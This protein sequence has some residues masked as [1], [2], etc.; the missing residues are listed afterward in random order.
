MEF[1]ERLIRSAIHLRIFKRKPLSPTFSGTGAWI[2]HEGKE[3]LIT[4]QHVTLKRNSLALIDTGRDVN[5]KR[6]YIKIGGRFDFIKI[7]L[8]KCIPE[9]I[10]N[11]ILEYTKNPDFTNSIIDDPEIENSFI[12]FAYYPLYEPLKLKQNEI[13]NKDY[14]VP[15]SNKLCIGTHLN[16]I[17]NKEDIYGFA[18][19]IKTKTTGE[20][21]T[22][23]LVV[24]PFLKFESE[25]YGKIKDDFGNIYSGKYY[26]FRLVSEIKSKFD[27]QGTSG[28]PILDNHGKIFGLVAFGREKE[29]YIYALPSYVIRESINI[30]LS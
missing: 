30:S 13:R 12:D 27:Y 7:N 26:K 18:G 5:G 25:E 23:I 29:P 19:R 20:N 17:P 2:K 6:E 4:V 10:L 8:Q 11:K 9:K 24:H 3:F 16:D 14:Y 1:I 15:E 28:A 21:S 22:T